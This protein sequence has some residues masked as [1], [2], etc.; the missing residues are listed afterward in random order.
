M[1][2]RRSYKG[3][4]KPKNPEKYIGDLKKIIWR[5][6]WERGFFKWADRSPSVLK[7]ASEP[8]AIPYYD[9]G[10]KKQRKYY[11]DVYLETSS[12]KKILIEIK[13]AQETKP[14]KKPQRVTKKHL[15]KES[16]YTTNCCKWRAAEKLCQK[17]GW[18]FKIVTEN[19]LTNMGIKIIK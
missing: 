4:F 1:S 7:W 10:H 8:F 19:T 15:L 6:L 2:K 11:P 13:P 5:S 17:K 3:K 18:K 12:G 16:T 14:P 9:Q